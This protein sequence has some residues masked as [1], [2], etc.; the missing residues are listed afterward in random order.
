MIE[1]RRAYGRDYGECPLE[2]AER[3]S[4]VTYVAQYP[5]VKCALLCGC[6]CFD[7]QR[8]QWAYCALEFK[9]QLHLA[10]VSE[11]WFSSFK[12][13]VPIQPY[14]NVYRAEIDASLTVIS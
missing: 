4:G 10:A 8:T 7:L 11:S 3:L 2:L 13:D 12:C 1:P 9:L 14:Y 5:A 6:D